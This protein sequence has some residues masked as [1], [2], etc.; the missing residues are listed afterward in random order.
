MNGE[1]MKLTE[2]SLEI[3]MPGSDDNL[4]MAFSSPTP[5]M[6]IHVGDIINPSIWEGSQSPMKVLRATGVEHAIW[7][8]GG[9]VK[10][11]IMI[12]TEEVDA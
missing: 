11:K 7:E 4:W 9:N 6:A 12:Y 1:N 10:H 3:Y 2:Y 5:F 8:L